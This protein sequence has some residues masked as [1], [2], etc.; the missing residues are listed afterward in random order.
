IRQTMVETLSL[1]P[2]CSLLHPVSNQDR[3]E[4]LAPHHVSSQWSATLE[5]GTPGK[6][7]ACEVVQ[8]NGSAS[9]SHDYPSDSSVHL[10]IYIEQHKDAKHGS[11]SRPVARAL[12]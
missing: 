9:E 1:H 2:Q 6:P 8:G 12:E 5:S 10:S 11:S 7:I 4:D 3:S